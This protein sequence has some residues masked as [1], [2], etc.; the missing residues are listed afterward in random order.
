MLSDRI[1]NVFYE[2]YLTVLP[3]GV[4]A[5][6]LCFLPTFI[7][8]Y[9]LLGLDIRSGLLNLLC[10]IMILSDT[11]GFMALWGISYNAVSLI[12]L[13]MV[14]CH[15]VPGGVVGDPASLDTPSSIQ[16]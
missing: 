2:Q 8:C 1:S 4:F 10:I 12:N 14:M 5:L 13:V 3:E 16:N 11:I 9:L 7:V 15:R 6:A